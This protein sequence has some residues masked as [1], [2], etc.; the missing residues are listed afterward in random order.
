MSTILS[1]A[2]LYAALTFSHDAWRA[3]ANIKAITFADLHV[4][5]E[6]RA[7]WSDLVTRV[8]T[9]NSRCKLI[10]GKPGDSHSIETVLLHEYGHMASNTDVHS[11]NPHSVMYYRL[12]KRQVITEEDRTWLK[13]CQ[14]LRPQA[15]ATMTSITVEVAVDLQLRKD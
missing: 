3:D 14:R 13:E 11:E 10:A 4:P 12:G 1:S 7:A 15:Q 2:V 8:I 5:C 6:Q 9:L